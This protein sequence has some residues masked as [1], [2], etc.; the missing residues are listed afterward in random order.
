M[1]NI[2]CRKAKERT[3]NAMRRIALLEAKGC[4]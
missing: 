4:F 2:V 3:G 1:V